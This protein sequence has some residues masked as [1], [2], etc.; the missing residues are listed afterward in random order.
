MPGGFHPGEQSLA[1]HAVHLTTRAGQPSRSAVSARGALQRVQRSNHGAPH[2]ARLLGFERREERAERGL[3]QVVRVK[4]GPDLVHG[5]EKRGRKAGHN[6]NGLL[7]GANR[8]PLQRDERQQ[9]IREAFARRAQRR[10]ALHAAAKR[11]VESVSSAS[12][13]AGETAARRSV[14]EF[15]DRDSLRRCVSFDWRYGVCERPLEERA[16]TTCSR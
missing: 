8:C 15:P 6:G 4:L 11:S 14:F 5:V 10:T 1:E 9:G 16:T 13:L 12:T 7:G 2:T 3:E